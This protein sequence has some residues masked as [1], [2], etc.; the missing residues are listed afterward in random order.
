[1]G[2]LPHNPKPDEQS[3]TLRPNAPSRC[4]QFVAARIHPPRS[5]AKSRNRQ[6]G[7]GDIGIKDL[8]KFGFCNCIEGR[9]F[10]FSQGSDLLHSHQIPIN[11]LL[12]RRTVAIRVLNR[13]R[14]IKL[15]F[16]SPG[17]GYSSLFPGEGLVLLVD[18][19]TV[20]LEAD[21]RCI[22]NGPVDPFSALLSLPYTGGTN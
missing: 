21:L 9:V 15:C 8:A 4:P 17:P 19:R 14:L 1:M 11:H 10:G 7:A 12:E 6:G 13:A 22:A 3:I 5:F 18:Y 2:D 20:L 16:A